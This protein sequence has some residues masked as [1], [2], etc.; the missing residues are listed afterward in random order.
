MF[1]NWK[2]LPVEN[3]LIKELS[4]SG[5]GKDCI[6]FIQTEEPEQQVVFEMRDPSLTIDIQ[7]HIV[8]K[9]F[10]HGDTVLGVSYQPFNKMRLEQAEIA[11]PGDEE[12]EWERSL[13]RFEEGRDDFIGYTIFHAR[14]KL[15]AI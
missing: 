4:M 1:Q 10:S 6:V 8:A 2:K 3:A 12:Q 15:V 11:Y 5:N 13:K 9:S 7:G 14:M